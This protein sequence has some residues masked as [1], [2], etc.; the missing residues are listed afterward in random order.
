[1][2]CFRSEISEGMMADVECRF[3]VIR[4]DREFE[5]L[6]C[7]TFASS[8]HG[9]SIAGIKVTWKGG[10]MWLRRDDDPALARKLPPLRRS[11]ATY[12]RLEDSLQLWPFIH[13]LS[14]SL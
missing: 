5:R 7:G 2:N 11:I 8:A 13:I 12:I 9:P 1:M 14:R 10:V 4:E 6:K 3:V